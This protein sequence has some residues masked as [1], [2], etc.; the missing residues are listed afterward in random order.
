MNINIHAQNKIHVRARNGN[1]RDEYANASFSFTPFS[2]YKQIVEV[3]ACTVCLYMYCVL[4]SFRDL[5][6]YSMCG[7]VVS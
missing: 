3:F 1:K 4:S 6:L 2:G 5:K 7:H